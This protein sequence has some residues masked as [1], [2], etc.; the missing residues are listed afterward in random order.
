[1]NLYVMRHGQTNWNVLGKVQGCTDIE[2]NE[3][4][5]K[6]AENAKEE[7]N[8]CDVDLII[9]SPLKRAKKTAEIVSQDKKVPVICDARLMERGYGALEGKNPE[10]NKEMFE[11]VWNYEL[12][13]KEYGIE[14]VVTCCNRVSEF[15]DEIKGKYQDKNVLLV[16]HGGTAQA[17]QAYFTGIEEDGQVPRTGIVNCEIRKYELNEIFN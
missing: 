16:T 5:I 3:T 6:Q 12:N 4:G 2:L 11:N 8:Q 10:S 15:L 17:I 7:F 9:A 14:P 13:I 1:M